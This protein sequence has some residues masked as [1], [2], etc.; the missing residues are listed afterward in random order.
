MEEA[1]SAETGV[2]SDTVQE[3]SKIWLQ[4]PHREK[5]LL[6]EGTFFKAFVKPYRTFDK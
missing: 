6:S 4:Q 2:G 5:D 1:G 3:T